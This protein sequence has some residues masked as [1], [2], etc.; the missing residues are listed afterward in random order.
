MFKNI[1][2][3][4][5]FV[6]L[7]G[8]TA[9]AQF[10]VDSDTLLAEGQSTEFELVAPSKISNLSSLP[11]TI[12]WTRTVNDIPSNWTSAVCDINQCFG[13]SVS[14]AEFI[15]P[16][17]SVEAM[18]YHFYPASNSGTGT[19]IVRLERK[20]NPSIYLDI[21]IYCQSYGLSVKDISNHQL[22]V[23][24]NPATDF[25]SIGSESIKEGTFEITNLLGEK[26]I[27][28][29]YAIAQKI[30]ISTLPKGIYFITIQ[31]ENS[32]ASRKLVIE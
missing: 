20:S 19:M 17:N 16:P 12:V 23:F 6:L 14:T 3:A 22:N 8:L 4:I 25:I 24:P 31:N 11:D 13:V 2:F 32:I 10:I 15:L 26:L 9:N 1:L 30:D 7:I 29:S 28:N 27:S 21:V 18:S 5:S